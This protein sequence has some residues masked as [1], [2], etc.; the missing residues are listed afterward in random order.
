MRKTASEVITTDR[1]K[2]K[3]AKTAFWVWSKFP[4]EHG[5]EELSQAELPM[6]KLL[7]I[8]RVYKRISAPVEVV[9]I[10]QL[11]W[12][13][14]NRKQAE[15]FVISRITDENFDEAIA[16][17][18]ICAAFPKAALKHDAARFVRALDELAEQGYFQQAA[19]KGYEE[20]LLKPEHIAM[21]FQSKE[22]AVLKL[23]FDCLRDR[24][25]VP[26]D[27]IAPLESLRTATQ[28]D[29][30]FRRSTQGLN[31]ARPARAGAFRGVQSGPQGMLATPWRD[32]Q[33]QNR[34]QPGRHRQRLQRR[35]AQRPRCSEQGGRREAD[36][37]RRRLRLPPERDA[38][39]ALRAWRECRCHKRSP[40]VPGRAG[41]KRA[42]TVFL[43]FHAF[44]LRARVVCSFLRRR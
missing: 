17:Y 44:Y 2:P 29:Q 18:K 15:Q 38:E 14:K 35:L 40:P 36:H 5:D 21:M 9:H 30:A 12:P 6:S 27:L 20:G 7:E 26:A 41:Y 1:P 19:V 13:E 25:E 43:H 22:L 33:E 32:R 31:P 37:H 23:A 10:D 3:A 8:A 34:P 4:D 28:D 16:G 42:L 11:P 39:A 24:E